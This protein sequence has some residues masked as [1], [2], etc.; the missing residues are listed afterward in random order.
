MARRAEGD[1]VRAAPPG[2]ESLRCGLG[3]EDHSQHG[4]EADLKAAVAQVGG[5]AEKNGG[6]GDEK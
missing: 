3:E 2:P 5:V 6:D 4:G 1:G